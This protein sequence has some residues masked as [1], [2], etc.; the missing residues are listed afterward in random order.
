LETVTVTPGGDRARAYPVRVGWGLLKEAEAISGLMGKRAFII[1]DK[2]LEQASKKLSLS[3][4]QSGWSVRDTT[5]PVSESAKDYRKIFSLYTELI[6]AKMDRDSVLFAL[7]GGVIGDLSGFIAATYLR[8]IRWVGVPSTLLAQVDSSIGGK[9]GVNH[10]LGKNLIGAFHQPSLVLCDTELLRSLSMRDRVSGMAEMIKLGLTFDP[11]HYDFL[12]REHEKIL[13]LEP[14]ALS[15]AIAQSIRWKANVVEQDEY[16]RTGTRQIL[17]FGHTIGHALES[18]TNYKRF[19][20]GEAILWGMRVESAVSV[21]RGHILESDLQ[22]VDSFFVKLEV[23]DLPPA[24]SVKKLVAATM[25][26]KKVKDGK[27]NYI[28]IK[29]VGKAV[30]DNQVSEHDVA[31][32]LSLLG[33]SRRAK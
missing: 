15:L 21:I 11:I 19:R 16:E 8:G 6:D 14:E 29:A 3:L 18:I 17:N 27:V 22:K 20:H 25:T 33:I 31:A 12:V 28:L 32:A 9:T 24:L 2:K 1:C 26:D 23:P 30:S 10:V 4:R 13:K 7:G 5:L